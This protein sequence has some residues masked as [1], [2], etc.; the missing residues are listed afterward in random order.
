MIG[1]DVLY[2]RAV[3]DLSRNKESS[4]N[5]TRY[6]KYLRRH[7]IGNGGLVAI[8]ILSGAYVAGTS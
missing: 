2:P 8:T 6:L 5:F 4:E 7:A 3:L 1:L